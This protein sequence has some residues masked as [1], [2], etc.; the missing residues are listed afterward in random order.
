[1]SCLL[2][3]PQTDINFN[4]RFLFRSRYTYKNPPIINRTANIHVS[5]STAGPRAV[6]VLSCRRQPT[7]LPTRRHPR[8]ARRQDERLAVRGELTNAQRWMVPVGL[9][10]TNYHWRYWV[11]NVVVFL[12]L[13]VYFLYNT[14]HTHKRIFCLIMTIQRASNK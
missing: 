14:Y 7:E 13:R 5:R 9:H 11:R 1:M 2:A 8:S 12:C 6:R 10:W 4:I 3:I